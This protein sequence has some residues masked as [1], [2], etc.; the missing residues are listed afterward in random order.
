MSFKQPAAPSTKKRKLGDESPQKNA[1]IPK[2]SNTIDQSALKKLIT[3]FEKAINQNLQDREKYQSEPEKFMESEIKLDTCVKQLQEQFV[4]NVEL[5]SSFVQ[6]GGVEL[7]LSLLIHENIDIMLDVLEMV[8][9]FTETDNLEENHEQASTLI[10]KLVEQQIIP[11]VVSLLKDRQLSDD[12][13]EHT[14]GIHDILSIIEN[15]IEFDPET[16]ITAAQKTPLLDYCLTSVS[17]TGEMKPTQLYAAE[18]LTILMTNPDNIVWFTK[19]ERLEKLLQ[20]IAYYRKHKPADLT[21]TELL[22]NLF[23]T[24]CY[25]LTLQDC[26]D[27]FRRLEG[28]E[29]LLL[30]IKEKKF[31]RFAALKSLNHSLMDNV[32]NC[33]RLV[34][35]QG[36]KTLFAL[37][38]QPSKQQEQEYDEHVISC[39]VSLIKHCSGEDERDRTLIKLNEKCDRL[40]QLFIKYYVGVYDFDQRIDQVKTLIGSDDPDDLLRERLSAGLFLLQ[41]V[42]F[43]IC[44]LLVSFDQ[45]KDVVTKEMKKHNIPN[46]TLLSVLQFQVDQIEDTSDPDHELLTSIIQDVEPMLKEE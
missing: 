32:K 22:E 24:L 18:I 10:Q 44:R 26:R 43:L 23:D 46:N 37:F 16:S 36:L 8:A 29:L 40:L 21:E 25:V 15:L 41:Q 34:Q 28:I 2:T 9:E 7:L 39:I 19:Q 20:R 3:Q 1:K 42:C 11:V 12:N 33:T 45:V 4:P 27:T 5:Y 35:A 14:K 6:W 30:L 31:T 38:T 13:A 17:R